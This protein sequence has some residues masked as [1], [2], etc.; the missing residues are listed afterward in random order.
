MQSLAPPIINCDASKPFVCFL[1]LFVFFVNFYFSKHL[2]ITC[3]VLTFL[4]KLE[5][6]SEPQS[7]PKSVGTHLKQK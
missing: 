6:I 4:Q 7:M 3:H 1:T 5:K 2:L